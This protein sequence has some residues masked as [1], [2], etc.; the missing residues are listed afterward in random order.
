MSTK[1]KFKINRDL[2][3]NYL[4]AR[5]NGLSKRDAAE[6]T[7][8]AV[9]T[10]Y[11]WFNHSKE[12]VER[13]NNSLI[14]DENFDKEADPEYHFY[15]LYYG[16]IQ[17]DKKKEMKALGNLQKLG[18]DRYYTDKDGVYRI[19]KAGSVAANERILKIVNPERYDVSDEKTSVVA[20]KVVFNYLNNDSK[21][22]I[23]KNMQGAQSQQQ[24]NLKQDDEE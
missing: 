12:V 6:W 7:G 13:I 18:E 22:D 16:D 8:I 4:K 19:D 20:Q 15:M 1:G 3:A 5:E 9:Q 2:V 23:L 24:K 17:G 14:E 10:V 21:K 11:N